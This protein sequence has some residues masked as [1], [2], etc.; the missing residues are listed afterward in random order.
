MPD[1]ADAAA[2]DRRHDQWR[3]DDECLEHDGGAARSR[4]PTP[5]ST[6]R[7][8]TPASPSIRLPALSVKGFYPL[9]LDRQLDRLHRLQSADRQWGRLLNDGSGGAIVNTP[10]LSRGEMRPRRR[11]G[12]QPRP[13]RRQHQYPQRAVRRTARCN[14][15]LQADYRLSPRSNSRAPRA[16]RT[17]SLRKP[18]ARQDVGVPVQARLHEPRRS[19]TLTLLLSY[20]YDNRRGSD[21]IVDPYEPLLSASLGTVAD[22][23]R[24]QRGLLDPQRST[25]CASSTSPTATRT[26]SR[27]GSTGRRSPA[28]DAGLALQYKA[29]SYPDSAYGRNGTASRPRSA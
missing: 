1:R 4:P 29:S 5:R 27:R 12:A 22:R 26:S 21:Y 24:H 9:L 28:L 16:A 11:P 15:S 23:H 3:L 17:S 13:E 14:Y 6:R 8:P 7:S 19:P 18:R 20:E 10:G 2:A 25:R